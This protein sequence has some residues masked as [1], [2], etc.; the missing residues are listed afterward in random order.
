[1]YHHIICTKPNK[2]IF[3]KQCRALEKNIP[4]IIKLELLTDVDCSQ[5]QIYVKDGKKITVHNS[6]YMDCVYIDSEIE[7]EQFFK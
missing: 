5:T 4:N 2:S 6:Y 1:M 3:V 7:L